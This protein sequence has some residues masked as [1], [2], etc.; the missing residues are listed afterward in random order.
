MPGV[1]EYFRADGTRVRGHW[2]NAAG[3]S[4][5]LLV[6]GI[7]VALVV[8]H[9]AGTAPAGAGGKPADGKAAVRRAPGPKPTSV[10]P[11]RWPG[12]DKPVPQP[13]TTVSYP[14]RFPARGQ[15]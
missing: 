13:T 5:Q 14:I 7:V 11:I 6:A 2:R 8:A 15:R 3:S 1:R 10:Y 4:G 12:W 9:G